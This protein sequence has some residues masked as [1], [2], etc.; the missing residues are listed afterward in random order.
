MME[1]P[2]LLLIGRREPTT[3]DTR[4]IRSILKDRVDRAEWLWRFRWSERPADWDA[5]NVMALHG[6]FGSWSMIDFQVWRDLG[7]TPAPE[8]TRVL[9][10]V[11]FADVIDPIDVDPYDPPLLIGAYRLLGD[12][13]ITAPTK[14]KP[15][16]GRSDRGFQ[17]HR[18]LE[19]NGIL[20][21]PRIHT[22]RGFAR[23]LAEQGFV[24][25]P[26]RWTLTRVPDA[27]RA[28]NL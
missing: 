15:Y 18:T 17:F 12:V 26:D 16:D 10:Y 1:L 8:L 19:Q 24:V 2:S 11:P 23:V 5:W 7:A 13:P 14:K 4:T 22:K 27:D 3:E 28:V 21:D 20:S 6:T 9:R 25:N